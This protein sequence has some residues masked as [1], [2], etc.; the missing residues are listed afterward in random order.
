MKR[1]IAVMMCAVMTVTLLAVSAVPVSAAS[2]TKTGSFSVTGATVNYIAKAGPHASKTNYI[3]GYVDA[4]LNAAVYACP[5][6][7]IGAGVRYQ[8]YPIAKSTK[9]IDAYGIAD[10][11]ESGNVYCEKDTVGQPGWDVILRMVLKV[12]ITFSGKARC[13]K[14]APGQTQLYTDSAA[15]TIWTNYAKSWAIVDILANFLYINA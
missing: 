8:Q 2:Y 14:W 12:S 7:V 15:E 4:T 9:E 5:V 10:P 11:I 3:W 1:A 13:F 6:L